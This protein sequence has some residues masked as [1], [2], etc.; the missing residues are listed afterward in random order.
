MNRY[1]LVLLSVFL[2]G[3]SLAQQANNTT[4]VSTERQPGIEAVGEALTHDAKSVGTSKQIADNKKQLAPMRK[5]TQRDHL[6][7]PDFAVFD[8]WVSMDEDVDYDGYYSTFTLEFDVDTVYERAEVYAVLY[9]ARTDVYEQYHVTSVFS[10]YGDS[11]NDSLLVQSELHQ[12]FPPGEYDV[13][14]EVYDAYD[15]NLVAATDSFNDADLAFLSLESRNH[16]VEAEVIIV[17]HESGGALSTLWLALLAGIAGYR[18][19]RR[20]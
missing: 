2:C 6:D 11:S 18:K 3:S 5:P 8:A 14:I 10:I 12:G 16:E 4:V 9:L 17:T 19:L 1:G 15:D 7:H 20:A 13:L